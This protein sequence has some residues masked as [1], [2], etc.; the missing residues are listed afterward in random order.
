MWMLYI[1]AVYSAP[2]SGSVCHSA[3]FPWLKEGIVLS[4]LALEESRATLITVFDQA[5]PYFA[6][7][8]YFIF[9][10]C[11]WTGHMC[12][13][14]NNS[15]EKE[16][17]PYTLSLKP[18]EQL[19]GECKFTLSHNSMP[20]FHMHLG[21]LHEHKDITVLSVCKRCNSRSTVVVVLSCIKSTARHSRS[22]KS[23]AFDVIP[24]TKRGKFVQGNWVGLK[25]AVK[26]ITWQ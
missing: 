20:W 24:F 26:R 19:S 13:P 11:F 6:C 5:K 16:K 10:T 18:S 8:F 3:R 15:V 14:G 9:F 4:S 25:M 22:R 2:F 21:A 7:L 1:V 12:R 17:C 23:S